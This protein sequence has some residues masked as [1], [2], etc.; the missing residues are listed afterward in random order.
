M[1]MDSKFCTHPSFVQYTMCFCTFISAY[2]LA[3]SL[4]YSKMVD[5][6]L[7]QQVNF[8]RCMHENRIERCCAT[9]T[10]LTIGVWK[11]QL[12]PWKKPPGWWCVVFRTFLAFE[13]LIQ[14]QDQQAKIATLKTAQKFFSEDKDRSFEAKVGHFTHLREIPF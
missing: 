3:L 1:N 14:V 2:L 9:F 13:I 7:L 10:I 4:D 6:P 8:S 11:V 12:C 5:R